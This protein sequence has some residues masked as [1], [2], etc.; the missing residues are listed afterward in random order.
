MLTN[1]FAEAAT[2]DP[3][4]TATRDVQRLANCWRTFDAACVIA[5]SHVA[6]YER[7][8]G[9]QKFTELQFRTYRSMKKA[10]AKYTRLD[11]SAPWEPFAGDG[12]LY[13]FVPY[14][15]VLEFNGNSVEIQAYFI[16][17]SDDSGE[18]WQFFD[19]SLVTRENIRAI[20]P[21]YDGRPLPPRP[22]TRN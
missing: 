15:S 16:G 19:G 2:A 10:G 6:S 5:L 13:I 22:L 3:A 9:S 14:A 20:I 8:G 7:L 12:H 1:F 17:I 18:T 11:V 4:A 21:S